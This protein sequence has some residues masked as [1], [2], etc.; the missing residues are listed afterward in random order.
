MA[1]A[2]IVGSHIKKITLQLNQLRQ[3][4]DIQ[5]IE[6]DVAK[7]SA[8]HE[9]LLGE[10][11]ATAQHCHAQNITP[12]IYTSRTELEFDDQQSRLAFG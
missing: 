6:I 2:V 10:I 5:G 3:Q 4:A 12:V 7:I 8:R 11:I 9:H 1:G